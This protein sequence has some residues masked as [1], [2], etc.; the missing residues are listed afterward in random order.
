MNLTVMTPTNV[1]V[2]VS[3]SK[4]TAIAP[5]HGSFC[6]LPRHIDLVSALA[7]GILTYESEEGQESYIA[8]DEGLLVKRGDHVRVSVKQAVI[9]GDLG[10]LRETIEREFEQLDDL[11]RRARSA[12]ARLE[13][14]F[15]RRYAE[16][17][18]PEL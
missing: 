2:D 9:G 11:E 5:T 18:E 12:L 8:V 6:L 17:T 7:P 4:V 15:V 13:A 14:D 10:S 1:V 3:A 16:I